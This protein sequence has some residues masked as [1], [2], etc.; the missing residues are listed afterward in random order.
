MKATNHYLVNDSQRFFSVG[1]PLLQSSDP[2]A[3]SVPETSHT[4]LQPF[5]H[6]LLSDHTDTAT[7]GRLPKISS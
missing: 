3:L 7:V 4:H 6:I 2:A 1:G 5:S